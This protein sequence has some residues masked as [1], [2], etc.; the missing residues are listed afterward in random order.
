MKVLFDIKYLYSFLISFISTIFFLELLIK[1][2]QFL[3]LIDKPGYRKIHNKE[4]PTVG[5]LS[6]ILSFIPTF[7][8]Y[9][10]FNWH[11]YQIDM[12]FICLIFSTTI[13][14][15]TGLIDDIKGLKASSKFV[16]QFLA[17]IIVVIGAK[18]SNIEFSFFT[19]GDFEFLSIALSIVYIVGITNA[20]NLI[21]GL[22]GLAG[23]V[24]LIITISFLGL[25]I[26]APAG[27]KGGYVFILVPLIGSLIAFLIYNK[28]PAKVFLGDTG[29]LMLGWIFA[30]LSLVYSQKTS[31]TLSILIPVMVLGLPA[32]DVIF[33][34]LKRFFVRHQYGYKGRLSQIFVGD[35]NH[36]HH[37]LLSMGLSK[38]STVLIL[39]AITLLTS[40]IALYFYFYNRELYAKENIIY[41]L[42]CVFAIIFV[43]RFIVEWK[44][45][46]KLNEKS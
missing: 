43:V 33:V 5:G 40:G 10:F 3:G 6:I 16:F 11:S 26:L 38:K 19:N 14:F 32:F 27:V 12:F 37:L 28:E 42:I 31:F 44:A 20:I 35:Q 4:I 23:G 15:L 7:V 17:A 2:S 25:G 18:Y 36:M 8:V 30:I 45:S 9:Y 29:S 46:R 22:D 34:M 39:Y 1:Q 24:S 41:A 13:I 21:D